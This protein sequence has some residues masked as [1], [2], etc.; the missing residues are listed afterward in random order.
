MKTADMKAVLHRHFSLLLPLLALLL[1]G[2]ESPYY[3]YRYV[4]G[5]TAILRDGY[6]VAPPNAPGEVHAAIA[7][8]NRIAGLPY[9]RGGGHRSVIDSAYD[10]SGAT[11]F[12][13]IAAD[14]LRSPM[15]STAFR[16][17][18]RSGEGEWIT[19]YARRGHVFL[20]VAGLRFDTGYNGAHRGP[21]W[22]TRSRPA[23]GAVLRHPAG[24]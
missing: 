16:R 9:A 12:L 4:P 15:P 23:N 24:L 14:Q 8:G 13:L 5:R 3:S 1:S 21:Q 20:S 19:V 7:A 10:C 11:S 2:C 22:T 18:G 17:Y 6:A